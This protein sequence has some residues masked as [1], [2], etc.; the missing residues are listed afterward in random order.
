MNNATVP[1]PEDISPAS[2]VARVPNSPY[3]NRNLRFVTACDSTG[4]YRLA[5]VS[6]TCGKDSDT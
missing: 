6:H 5:A 4:R 3:F 2:A 1:V